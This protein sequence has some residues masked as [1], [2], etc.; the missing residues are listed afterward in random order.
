MMVENQ[1]FFVLA[2]LCFTIM[3]VSMFISQFYLY[4]VHIL[5][6]LE[7]MLFSFIAMWFSYIQ[8]RKDVH[9]E[10]SMKLRK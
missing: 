10:N 8:G 7:V 4:P 2:L 1:N 6:Y 9:I 3:L 5:V